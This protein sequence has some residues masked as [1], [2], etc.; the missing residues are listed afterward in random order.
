[1]SRIRWGIHAP[2]PEMTQAPPFSSH[3]A[4]SSRDSCAMCPIHRETDI[5]DL[6]AAITAQKVCPTA[7]T[8]WASHR[9]LEFKCP[10]P[11]L[12][13][14]QPPASSSLICP[15]R[16]KFLWLDWE[17]KIKAQGPYFL[18]WIPAHLNQLSPPHSEETG[19]LLGALIWKRLRNCLAFALK[20]ANVGEKKQLSCSFC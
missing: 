8:P 2:L 7:R 10:L 14:P 3:S 13:F 1:M 9:R 4:Q 11:S 19:Q 20:G 16:I 18:C 6:F 17:E 12:F 15:G 5:L